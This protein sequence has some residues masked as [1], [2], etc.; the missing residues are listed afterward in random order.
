MPNWTYNGEEI[1]E[2]PKE[3]SKFFGFI[4]TIEFP[5]T[6]EVYIGQKQIKL[7]NNRIIGK[8]ELETYPDKRKLRRRKVKRGKDKGSWVYFEER[9]TEDWQEYQSSSDIVK[10]KIKDGEEYRKEIL[11]FVK[12]QGLMNYYETREIICRGAMEDELFINDHV[13][14]YYKRNIIGN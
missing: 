1:T 14:N 12:K 4:Y 10:Q 11:F 8:R 2:I 7:K 9:F 6:G 3:F 13:G 5:N